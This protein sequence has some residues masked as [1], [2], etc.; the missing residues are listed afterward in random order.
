MDSLYNTYLKMLTTPF[1]DP[2]SDLPDISPE[3]YPALFALADRHCTLPFVL[4]YFRNTGLYPQILQKSKHMMLNYY[5]IDQFTRRTVSL[6]EK[7]GIT[8][9]VMK[10]ISLAASYPVPEYRKLGDLDLYINDKDAFHCAEQ[11]LHEN[12]YLDEEEL[13]DH[14]TTYRYTFEKTG[15]SFLLELHY[16]VVGVYQYKPANQL[17]DEVFSAENLKAETQEINGSSYHVFPPTEYVFYMIHHMLK[18]YLYSGFGIR[19]L[20]DF[21]FYLEQHAQE[22]DFAKI[23]SWC[24]QS[25]ILHLYESV[26]ETCRISEFTGDDRSGCALRSLR[27]R[28]FPV[29]DPGGWGSRCG[30]ITGTCWQSFL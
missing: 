23:H 11:I 17:I 27:L 28:C 5:Q 6:L 4:P 12:G 2:S 1:D 26:L 10:G 30:C 8:C 3:D 19:L 7:H 9:F 22:V 21:S 20:F 24:Q 16:R 14:H 18:H 15:R 25:H 13:S 29:Q